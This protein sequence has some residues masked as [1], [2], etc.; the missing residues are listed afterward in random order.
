MP[1]MARLRSLRSTPARAFLRGRSAAP[2]HV[3]GIGDISASPSRPDQSGYS[4]APFLAFVVASPSATHTGG[5][6]AHANHVVCA[7]RTIER[8]IG[9]GFTPA[10]WMT[11]LC[12][13]NEY[14]SPSGGIQASPVF[15]SGRVLGGRRVGERPL[16]RGTEEVFARPGACFLLVS[17]LCTSKEKRPAVGQP[18][19]SCFSSP[20]PATQ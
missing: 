6:L 20:P 8:Q 16:G 7:P 3:K 19:T 18:P 4:C 14:R 9:G 17:F 2:M 13:C 15:E 5:W 11:S 12:S 1:S 10:S